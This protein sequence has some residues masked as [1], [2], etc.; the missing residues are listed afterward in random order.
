MTYYIEDDV[1]RIVALFRL[2][3]DRLTGRRSPTATAT[4]HTGP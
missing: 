2:N 3:Y 1:G 4:A